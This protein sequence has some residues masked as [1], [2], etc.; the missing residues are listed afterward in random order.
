MSPEE[1]I[2][3][4]EAKKAEGNAAFTSGQL[5][6][7]IEAY[8]A[9]SQ[10]LSQLL[11][12]TV[13]DDKRSAVNALRVTLRSNAAQA[14]LK[15][16][17]YTEAVKEADEGLKVDPKHPKCLFRKG[18]ALLALGKI[19]AARTVLMAA[20]KAAPGDAPV[21]AELEKA[22]KMEAAAAAKEKAAFGGIFNRGLRLSEDDSAAP[23]A[24]ASA[25]APEVLPAAAE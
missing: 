8:S 1:K 24:A 15:A 22:K 17:N 3:H 19:E 21:R 2:A 13:A 14:Q 7:A 25:A 18:S 20:A 11:D 5:Y 6:A 16:R 12:A 4:A 9:G 10:A 23:A